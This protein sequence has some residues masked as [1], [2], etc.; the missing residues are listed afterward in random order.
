MKYIY[1]LIL[2][3]MSAAAAAQP[4]TK[5]NVLNTV[6]KVADNVV[7]NTTYLYYDRE[8]GELI[9]DLQ[10]HGYNRNVT[11]QN[12]YNDWKYWNGVIHIAFNRL[13]EETGIARYANFAKKNF[14]LF[15]RDYEYLKPLYD[16]K[17]HWGFPLAQA[18]RITELDDCG[19]MG[20]SLIELYMTD[21]KP[22]YKEW[23]DAATEHIMKKQMRLPDGLFSRPHPH[24]NTVWADDLYMSV[25]FLAR[26]GALTGKAE[27]FDEAVKQ[28]ALFNKYLF[29]E[30][31][32]LM[33]HCYYDDLKANGG[34]FWGRCNG[35]MMMATADLLRLL[36]DSHPRRSEVIALLQRQ[37]L[38]VAQYQSPSGMWR[39]VLNKEDSYLETS[40]TA[41]FTY[42][43]ALAVNSGWID[44]RYHS[45]AVKGWRG[46]LTQITSEG[47][48]TNICEGTGIGNDIKFY[49]D[50]PA[51]YNDIHGLG[52]VFLAGI[53][54]AKLLKE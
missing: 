34:T 27:Y 2:A 10:Q 30:R 21:K 35:W 49:Y 4:L 14:E 23:I 16:G 53:E 44:R 11:P 42:S 20:A 31:T 9:A 50:R 12:G 15:F 46:I 40:C 51:P 45:I 29:D 13:G 22:A 6:K 7:K 18:I 1:C 8:T 26:M 17:N 28:V 33:W 25:P 19:A 48:V 32:G 39:Q 3:A 37:I 36:P 47:A 43:V 38:N 54:V 5:Q 52:A 24:H 41:M